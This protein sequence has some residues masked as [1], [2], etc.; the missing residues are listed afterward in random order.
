TEAYSQPGSEP[1]DYPQ[2]GFGPGAYQGYET[3][4]GHGT[5]PGYATQPHY[6]QQGGILPGGIGQAD[7]PS[8]DYRTEAYPQ[9]GFDQSGYGQDG[10]GPN[11]YDQSGYGQDAYGQPGFEQPGGPGYDDDDTASLGR[12]PLSRSGPP[13]SPQRLAGVRMV[14]YL[15][16]S[17][18]GVVVI[19]YLVIHLT[20]SG[21]N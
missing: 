19:V 6:G 16:A 5:Q 7:Q 13:R 3:Q 17:V 9:P 14:L 20:K 11:T 10:Y 21:A 18:L 8:E 2:N 4:P 15:A 1:S 12:A